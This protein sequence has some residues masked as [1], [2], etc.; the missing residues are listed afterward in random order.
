MNKLFLYLKNEGIHQTLEKILTKFLTKTGI[1][2]STTLFFI[3]NNK[4]I[5][6]VPKRQ[7]FDIKILTETDVAEFEKI[8][9]FSHIYG[10]DYINNHNQKIILVLQNNIIVA[11]AAAQTNMRR[12]IHGLGYFTLNESECW[13]GPTY[14]TKNNRNKG[15]AS[16]M[17]RYIQNYIFTSDQISTYYTSINKTNTPSVTSFIKSGFELLGEIIG[18]EH[19]FSVISD[20]N[21]IINTHFSS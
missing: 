16:L 11:Y 4:N 21:N 2:K 10:K 15:I 20:N 14:V 12:E 13:I 5:K 6:P 18:K 7:D 17:I 3:C 8:K 19:G 1:K 9:F